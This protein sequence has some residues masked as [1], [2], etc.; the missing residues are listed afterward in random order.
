MFGARVGLAEEAAEG[1]VVGQVRERGKLQLVERDV[2][3]VEVDG[4]DGNGRGREIAEHVA[5]A[6][7]DGDEP[8]ARLEAQ[9][10]EIDDRV[11]PDLRIDEAAE[12]EREQPLLDALP[13]GGLVAM[14]GLAQ[15]SIARAPEGGFLC[16]CGMLSCGHRSPLFPVLSVRCAGSR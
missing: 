4:G 3:R 5:A 7:R 1:G 12:G 8:L 13:G 11:L 14:H 9:R 15:A 6:R 10:V 2:R 16:G